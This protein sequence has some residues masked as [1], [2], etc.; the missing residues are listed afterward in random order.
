MNLNINIDGREGKGDA[1]GRAGMRS[2]RY[3]VVR[4]CG[5]ASHG[6]TM[7]ARRTLASF[8]EKLVFGSI[9]SSSMSRKSKLVVRLSLKCNVSK[10]RNS[11]NSK[12]L[13][14][15]CLSHKETQVSKQ[16]IFPWPVIFLI[17]QKKK[18]TMVKSTNKIRTNTHTLETDDVRCEKKASYSRKHQPIAVN[19]TGTVG[20]ITIQVI[21]GLIQER[22][23]ETVIHTQL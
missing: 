13:A 16:E 23:W 18:Q 15:Y 17:T 9:M 7:D 6:H 20:K 21:H 2:C 5:C 14:T 1:R 3:A 12:Y 22:K 11:I 8:F 4:V 19:L 10:M